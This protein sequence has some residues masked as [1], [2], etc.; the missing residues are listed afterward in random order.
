MERTRTRTTDVLV[1]VSFLLPDQP[2]HVLQESIHLPRVLDVVEAILGAPLMLD[3]AGL[4]AAE[5]GMVYKQG[6]HRDVL[7]IPQ[8]QIEEDAAFAGS[9]HLSPVEARMPGGKCIPVK[10]GEAAFYHNNLIHRGYCIFERPRR[11]LHMGYHCA[12]RPPT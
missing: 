9:K 12:K 2:N 6:W 5:P 11:T 8:D 1:R 4:M 3:N 7:Q 10:A